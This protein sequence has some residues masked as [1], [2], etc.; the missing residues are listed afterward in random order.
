[1]DFRVKVEDRDGNSYRVVKFGQVSDGV[2][3]AVIEK[4]DNGWCG[5]WLKAVDY[6]NVFG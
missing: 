1:M 2:F 4:E 3:K 5:R 6:F